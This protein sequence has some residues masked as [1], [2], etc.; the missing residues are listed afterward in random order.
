MAFA[1]IPFYTELS[2]YCF[3][4][5]FKHFWGGEGICLLVLVQLNTLLWQVSLSIWVYF[6]TQSMQPFPA[7]ET[8]R[9]PFSF[10]NPSG[11]SAGTSS[12]I[13]YNPQ[14][15]VYF[16]CNCIPYTVIHICKVT[17]GLLSILVRDRIYCIYVG[18]FILPL[19]RNTNIWNY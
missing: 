19:Q 2:F 1:E 8:Q 11:L 16:F 6:K 14:R 12:N 7:I 3:E 4:H 18:L 13:N 5:R 10:L 9:A 15:H 17:F